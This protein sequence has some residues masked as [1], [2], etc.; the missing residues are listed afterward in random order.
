MWESTTDFVEDAGEWIADTA[1]NA[2]DV[3]TDFFIDT[4]NAIGDFISG[5][6]SW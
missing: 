4:G 6:F 3:T 5:L 2:W 1:S